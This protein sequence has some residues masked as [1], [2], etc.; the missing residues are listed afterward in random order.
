MQFPRTGC[1]YAGA[2]VAGKWSDRGAVDILVGRLMIDPSEGTLERRV[3]QST[4][5][6]L[7]YLVA[8]GVGVSVILRLAR[9][10]ELSWITAWG[11]PLLAGLQFLLWAG[12]ALLLVVLGCAAAS[13]G[14]RALFGARSAATVPRILA[15]VVAAAVIAF[16]FLVPMC[17]GSL[18]EGTYECV[19]LARR[20][21]G[22]L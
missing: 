1:P 2:C 16:V 12:V 21:T 8:G 13:I 11:R 18:S 9:N 5:R 3:L 4:P 22:M 6:L 20:A 17:L 15:A 10:A 14:L 19:T 7:L